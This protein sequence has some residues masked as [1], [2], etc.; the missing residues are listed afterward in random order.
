MDKNKAEKVFPVLGE[1]GIFTWNKLVR[2]GFTDEMPF[3]R[4]QR[5]WTCGLKE[6]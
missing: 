3:E 5:M 6:F 4:D 2:E 1:G